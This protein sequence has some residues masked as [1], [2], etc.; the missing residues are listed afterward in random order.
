MSKIVYDSWAKIFGIRSEHGKAKLK[1]GI[2]I[3]WILAVTVAVTYIFYM[4]CFVID[5]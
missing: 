4:E 2:R 3:I 1:A 5:Y